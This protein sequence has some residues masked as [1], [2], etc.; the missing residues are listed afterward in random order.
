MAGMILL[1]LAAP[2]THPQDA[3]SQGSYQVLPYKANDPSLAPDGL[4]QT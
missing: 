4:A 1:L 3:I 2:L